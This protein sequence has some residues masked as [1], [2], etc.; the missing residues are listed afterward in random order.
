MNHCPSDLLWI[1]SFCLGPWKPHVFWTLWAS[2]E[3]CPTYL[4]SVFVFV[5]LFPC[6]KQT[7]L[8]T[9]TLIWLLQISLFICSLVYV[10]VLFCFNIAASFLQLCPRD[11]S[12]LVFYNWKL[13]L[14]NWARLWSSVWDLLL[15]AVIWKCSRQWMKGSSILLVSLLGDGFL[16][17]PVI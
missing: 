4:R 7:R 9:Q 3:Y 6:E 13:C 5:S 2:D 10:V 1:W 11:S 17:W 15:H 14:L 8:F 12:P 16:A